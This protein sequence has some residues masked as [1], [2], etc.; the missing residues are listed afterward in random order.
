MNAE[1][2]DN[3]FA[4]AAGTLTNVVFPGG[5]GIRVDTHVYTGAVVP[6][7]YDSMLAKIVAVG[8]TRESALLRM[9]RALGETRIEGVKT[10]VDICREIVGDPDFR[11]GGIGVAWL[12]A[13]LV[14]RTATV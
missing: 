3:N 2:P 10:T 14:R 12:P 5:P 4:P 9:E 8:R 1:D 7:F 6:P 13:F 11:A